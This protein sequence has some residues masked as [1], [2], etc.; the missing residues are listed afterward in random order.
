MSTNETDPTPSSTVDEQPE[1]SVGAEEPSSAIGMS[2]STSYDTP[3][4]N[5]SP[6]ARKSKANPC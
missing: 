1:S 2:N 6:A 5:L 4:Y 3:H